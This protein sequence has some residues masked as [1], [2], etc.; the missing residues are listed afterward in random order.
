[1]HTTAVRLFPVTTCIGDLV[2]AAAQHR[3]LTNDRFQFG[4]TPIS[5]KAAP[6][7]ASA[8]NT[9]AYDITLRGTRAGILVSSNGAWRF[10]P[11]SVHAPRTN[12]S[13]PNLLSTIADAFVD[14]DELDADTVAR[15][16]A[17]A[18]EHNTNAERGI[19]ALFEQA[20]A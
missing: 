14:N 1:M 17:W 20:S 18:N 10:M 2:A 12:P 15:I 3:A 5:P 9:L 7:I 19:E 11:T 16:D 8:P 4:A 13:L 6:M